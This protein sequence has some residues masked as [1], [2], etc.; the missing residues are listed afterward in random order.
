LP[1]IFEVRMHRR[2]TGAC[3]EVWRRIERHIARTLRMIF[4]CG[5]KTALV[6]TVIFVCGC[7]SGGSNDKW[8]SSRPETV[9]A[10]GM[11]TLNGAPLE[12]AQVVLIPT[13]GGLGGSAVSDAKGSFRLT[14][15]PPDDGVVPGSYKVMIAKSEVPEN[16]DPDSPESTVPKYAKSL[17][18]AKYSNPETSGLV[19]EIP[20]SGDEEIELELKE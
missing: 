13:S 1:A 10:A 2:L 5:L 20:D 11:I 8:K 12:G 4:M 7:S 9:P 18:P 17:I 14:T 3:T 6:G 19:I 15:F 16:P